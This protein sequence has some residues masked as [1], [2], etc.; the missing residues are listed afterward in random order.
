MQNEY[1][2]STCTVDMHH[3]HPA[4]T[5]SAVKI[6]ASKKIR[7]KK[8]RFFPDFFYMCCPCPFLQVDSVSSRLDSVLPTKRAI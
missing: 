3:G 2:A 4:C 7:Q 6:G 8:A 5:V 1:A